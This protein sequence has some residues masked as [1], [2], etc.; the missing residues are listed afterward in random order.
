MIQVKQVITAYHFGI[1][2]DEAAFYK[3]YFLKEKCNK[4]IEHVIYLNTMQST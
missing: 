3:K 1:T 4:Q 2:D